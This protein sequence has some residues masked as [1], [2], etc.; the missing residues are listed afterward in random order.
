MDRKRYTQLFKSANKSIESYSSAKDLINK[1][2]QFLD[3]VGCHDDM[4]PTIETK[5]MLD[6]I[7]VRE[8]P[9]WL[10]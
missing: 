2:R 9:E 1:V 6:I 3:R 5:I 8:G 4:R 10:L 7:D